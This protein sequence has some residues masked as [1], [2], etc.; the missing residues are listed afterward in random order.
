VNAPAPSPERIAQWEEQALALLSVRTPP[1]KVVAHLKYVGYPESV[2]RD[3]IARNRKPAKKQLRR[4]GVG[5]LLTG[6]GILACFLALSLIE[7]AMDI[8]VPLPAQIWWLQYFA[9]GMIFYGILQ[10]IFG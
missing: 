6:I 2:A 3:I 8:R 9:L 10:M 1:D 7:G 5:I 4:K